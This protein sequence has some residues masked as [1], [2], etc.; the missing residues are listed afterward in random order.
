M[1]LITAITI[2][3]IIGRIVFHTAHAPVERD[4]RTIWG[5]TIILGV[6]SPTPLVVQ[7]L[8]KIF[9]GS[10]NRMLRCVRSI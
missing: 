1:G 5:D 10:E 8:R 9:V 3:P 4:F 7:N 6:G 2:T